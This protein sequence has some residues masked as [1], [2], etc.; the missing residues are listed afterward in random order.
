MADGDREAAVTQEGRYGLDGKWDVGI[1]LWFEGVITD[2]TRTD[3]DRPD[4]RALNVGADYT[5]P[6][7]NGLHVLGE[8]FV[9]EQSSGIFGEGE[10]ASL[11]A[12]S[13]R[14]PIGLL[15][16]LSAIFYLDAARHD[17]YRFITWQRS[18]DR[19]QFY[20]MGFWNPDQRAIYQGQVTDAG[21]S[22]FTGRGVQIMAVFNH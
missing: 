1:G 2:Q 4:Q 21:Q 9:L 15:D 22:Y 17:T 19:W 13:L 6:I 20:M 5:F 3:I 18:Y 16:S 11:G 7:G 8:Y 10:G 14:Y 12:A